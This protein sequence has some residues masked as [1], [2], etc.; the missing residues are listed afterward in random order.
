MSIQTAAFPALIL[1]SLTSI[2]LLTLNDWRAR[3]ALLAIQYLG[4]F[5]LTALSLPVGMS[6]S[7]LVAG[8]M[9]G[10]VLGMVMISLPTYEHASK[11]L[12]VYNPPEPAPQKKRF[13]ARLSARTVF[14]LLAGILV[15]LIAV[16]LTPDVLDLV[17]G[18]APIQVLAA[19]VLLGIGLLQISLDI[20]PLSFIIGLLTIISGFEILY[21]SLE[22]SIL[23]LGLIALAT[24]GLALVGAYL[25]TAHL[26]E[27]E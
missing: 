27:S 18:V 15:V 9:A 26:M 25:L 3:I 5:F 23:V 6:V 16:S 19:L 20:Q 1:V 24:L 17:P 13:N 21:F 8:W 2:F 22:P 4:V 11:D 10:A 12:E 14:F 7:I